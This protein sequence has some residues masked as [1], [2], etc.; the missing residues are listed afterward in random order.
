M[1]Q[2]KT[3]GKVNSSPATVPDN[4][5]DFVKDGSNFVAIPTS[6][7]GPISSTCLPLAS[8][9]IISDFRVIPLVYKKIITKI[10]QVHTFAT[11]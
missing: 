9:P 1:K 2:S 8:R 4:E 7:P 5:S 6:P 3:S 10:L 11:K